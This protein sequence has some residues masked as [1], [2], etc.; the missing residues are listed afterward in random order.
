MKSSAKKSNSKSP[1]RGRGSRFRAGAFVLALSLSLPAAELA[2]RI[3]SPQEYTFPRWKFSPQYG[4]ELYPSVKM[5]HAR[6]GN[7]RL[8]YTINEYGYRGRPVPVA[9]TYDVPN[10]VV[11]G[12]SYS[13]GHGVN[14]GEEYPAVMARELEGNY[15]VI[16]LGVG[17]WGLTQHIRRYHDFGALYDPRVIILQFC[18]NDPTDNLVNSV[19]TISGGRFSFH[20]AGVEINLAKKYLSGSV[21]QKSQLY[22]LMVHNLYPLLE[23]RW[24]QIKARNIAPEDAQKDKMPVAEK[25][26]IELLE[27]FAGNLNS[28]HKRLIMIS[29]NGNLDGFP[30]IRQKVMELDTAGLLKYCEVTHWLD[31]RTGYGAPDGHIWGSKAHRVIGR[32]LAETVKGLE[33]Q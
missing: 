16:N 6:P 17:G 5:V 33:R 12:D 3:I 27:L 20:D 4:H 7:Y 13:F 18:G 14:D 19:T 26:Y 15:N 8:I 24:I 28:N 9:E 21:I 29:L 25:Y 11:L 2:I 10:I 31:G 32:K 30:H 22:N 1:G 23:R